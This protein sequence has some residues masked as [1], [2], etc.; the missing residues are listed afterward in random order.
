MQL[1]MALL[2]SALF[3][4]EASVSHY[5]S[6]DNINRD[7]G[8]EREQIRGKSDLSLVMAAQALPVGASVPKAAEK[9]PVEFEADGDA[10]SSPTGKTINGVEASVGAHLDNDDTEELA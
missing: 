7:Q 6:V 10:S 1:R 5:T 2:A 9:K 4:A 8:F 3:F